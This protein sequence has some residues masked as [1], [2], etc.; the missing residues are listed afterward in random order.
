M[1]LNLDK[2]NVVSFH[3]DS[4]SYM[5]LATKTLKEK[6]G[7]TFID[8]PDAD[9]LIHNQVQ[10]LL[11]SHFPEEYNIV[12]KIATL[13]GYRNFLSIYKD[14]CEH[15]KKTYLKMSTIKEIRWFMFWENVRIL[16]KNFGEIID[17][18]CCGKH[19]IKSAKIVMDYFDM[20]ERRNQF[21]SFVKMILDG[22]SPIIFG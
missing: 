12:K 18:I 13:F 16:S 9:H 20:P 15:A 3:H 21:H 5:Q 10:A 2:K 11:K 22:L 1:M 6:H 17:A 14:N 4:A 7:Y 19:N 8:V